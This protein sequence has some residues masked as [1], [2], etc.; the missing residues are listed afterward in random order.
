MAHWFVTFGVNTPCGHLY[1]LPKSEDY[2]A[3]RQETFDRFGR[4]WSMIYPI[5]QLEDQVQSYGLLQLRDDNETLIAL[6]REGYS[7]GS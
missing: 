5:D 4:K 7:L 1:W 2:M 6:Q 3:A